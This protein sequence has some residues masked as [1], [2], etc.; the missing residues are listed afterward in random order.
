MSKE[1]IDYGFG[2]IE[3][4]ETYYAEQSVN[5]L[6]QHIAD[7]EAKL[8]ETREFL[9]IAYEDIDE[10]QKE[11]DRLEQQ[12]EKSDAYKLR[13]ELAGADE[14]ISQLKQ[15]LAEKEHSIEMLNQHLTDK[16]LE[17][18]KADRM[19]RDCEAD[20]KFEQEKKNIALKRVSELT[21]QLAD[22]ELE[23]E[24]LRLELVD[25]EEYVKMLEEDR[26][27]SIN[28]IRKYAEKCK[29]HNQDK[30]ELLEKARTQVAQLEVIGFPEYSC[31]D[32][33]ESCQYRVDDIINTLIKEIKGE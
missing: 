9:K 17:V 22:K 21:K 11:N 10:L 29:N 14:T 31:V 28:I 3:T 7:L 4:R 2:V 33:F 23:N 5:E 1:I 25:K 8:A 30:I 12:L 6:K 27:T 26:A 15:Q 18:E 16:A 13:I 20:R 19:F 32:G 24:T